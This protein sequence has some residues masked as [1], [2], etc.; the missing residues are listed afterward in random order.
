MMEATIGTAQA[1]LARRALSRPAPPLTG[2]AL[3]CAGYKENT[4]KINEFSLVVADTKTGLLLA[5]SRGQPH[6]RSYWSHDDGN[7]WSKPEESA[8]KDSVNQHNHGCE[9]SIINVHDKL[10][11]FNPSGQ[12]HDARTNMVVR[13]SLDGGVTWPHSYPV[14]ET[15]DGGYSDMIQ[16]VNAKNNILLLAWGYADVASNTRN[17][18]LEH[19]DI[20]WCKE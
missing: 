3:L 13:C 2:L 11:F 10:F 15:M 5:N 4:N 16:V 9:A 18:H 17:I 1:S 8:L 12:G 19:I 20:N 14:T 7:T 6:R